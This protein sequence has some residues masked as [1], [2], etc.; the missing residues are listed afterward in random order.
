MWGKVKEIYQ[1]KGK[2]KNNINKT[3][4]GKNQTK[5]CVA[6]RDQLK[7]LQRKCILNGTGSH[8]R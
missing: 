3:Q 5:T 8:S 1:K 6:I 2:K 4:Q 7:S